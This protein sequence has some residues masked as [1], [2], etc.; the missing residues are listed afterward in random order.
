MVETRWEGFR[1]GGQWLQKLERMRERIF[2]SES[3]ERTCPVNT[4]TW[5]QWNWYW[6]SDLQSCTRTNYVVFITEFGVVCYSS[7]RKLIQPSDTTI[8]WGGRG[9]SELSTDLE[10]LTD[11]FWGG[12]ER[13]VPVL[14]KASGGGACERIQ[15]RLRPA[16]RSRRPSRQ[17]QI[18]RP[19]P[20]AG[21]MVRLYR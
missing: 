10:L 21:L 3:P 14:Q 11:Q 1:E 17:V 19:I 6:I 5:A 2:P 20:T 8:R 13:H 12:A 7:K 15:A 9:E 16:P 4:L 18:G